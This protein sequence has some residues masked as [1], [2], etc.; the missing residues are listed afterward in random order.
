MTHHELECLRSRLVG[1]V[2]GLQDI[3]AILADTPLPVPVY[4]QVWDAEIHREMSKVLSILVDGRCWI[5]EL[6]GR[7]YG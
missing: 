3:K 2:R 7:P 4:R 1:H 6:C 5:D